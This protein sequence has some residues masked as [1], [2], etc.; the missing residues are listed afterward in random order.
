MTQKGDAKSKEKLTHGLK[1]D[2]RYL[3]NFHASNLKSGNL[4]GS[5][6]SK[7]INIQMKTKRS[8]MSHGTEK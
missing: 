8:V 3:V 4:L 6:C 2:I 5:L 7:H 1:N